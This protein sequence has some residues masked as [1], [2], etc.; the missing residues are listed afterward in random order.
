MALPKNTK[1][2]TTVSGVYT[3]G[4]TGSGWDYGGQN[5]PI[6]TNQSTTPGGAT[7]VAGPALG[8][9]VHASRH[10]SH[11]R[12]PGG[13][14][15]TQTPDFS[16]EDYMAK[17][18]S[19]PLWG[20]GET[21]FQTSID[22]AQ[23][24]MVHDP[25]NAALVNYGNLD[26]SQVPESLRAAM[27]GLIDPATL[28]AAQGN[29]TSTMALLQQALQSGQSALPYQ[30]QGQ[31]SGS[32]LIAGRRLNEGYQLQ[33]KQALDQLLGVLTGGQAKFAAY[34]DQQR[35][36]WEQAKS[37]IADRLARQAEAALNAKIA[38]WKTQNIG[39]S[40]GGGGNDLPQEDPYVWNPPG[41]GVYEGYTPEG[42]FNSETQQI[43]APGGGTYQSGGGEVIYQ[44]NQGPKG[45]KPLY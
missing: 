20:T 41:S 38:A 33:S 42:T 44:A 30:L 16:I 23:S 4:Y 8:T 1:P 14:D 2:T 39:G 17:I 31:R 36:V 32:A 3:G 13:V 19:D 15:E 37:A 25:F 45:K 5:Y 35:A 7:A 27:Q 40:G 29:P 28:A 34:S 22:R 18:Q 43:E 26:M 24:Q 10:R 21:A 6:P 9:L 11:Q 12:S